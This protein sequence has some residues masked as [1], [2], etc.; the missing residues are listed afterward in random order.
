MFHSHFDQGSEASDSKPSQNCPQINAL[1]FQVSAIKLLQKCYTSKNY[2][3][4]ISD[5]DKMEET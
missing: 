3:I 5:K 2:Q 4:S 1:D